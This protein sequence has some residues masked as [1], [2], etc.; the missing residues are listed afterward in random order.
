MRFTRVWVLL[1]LSM[2]IVGLLQAQDET[3]TLDPNI[4]VTLEPSLTPSEAPTLTPEDTATLTLEPSLTPENTATL[5]LIETPTESINT[6]EVPAT[7]TD[8]PV[9]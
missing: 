9:T 1:G 8:I 5:P 4:T 3:P 2:F 7:N 6:L